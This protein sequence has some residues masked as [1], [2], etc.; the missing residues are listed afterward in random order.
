MEEEKKEETKEE[1]KEEEKA[2]P[3]GQCSLEDLGI[4]LGSLKGPEQAFVKGIEGLFC[5]LQTFKKLP[6]KKP[7]KPFD[8][9]VAQSTGPDACGYELR[10]FQLPR[11]C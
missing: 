5:G 4:D 6:A 8:P 3:T 2:A 9:L 7:P 10:L 1:V 11:D